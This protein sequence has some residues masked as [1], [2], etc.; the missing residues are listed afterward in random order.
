MAKSLK[1]INGIISKNPNSL[2]TYEISGNDRQ[3]AIELLE[4]LKKLEQ[5]KKEKKDG[6]N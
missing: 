1:K 3:L 4:K 2:T 6:T 5:L